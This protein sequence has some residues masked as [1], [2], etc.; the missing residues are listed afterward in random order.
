MNRSLP[1]RVAPLAERSSSVECLPITVLLIEDNPDSAELV[2]AQLS[3]DDELFRFEWRPNLTSALIRIAEPGIDVVLLDLSLPE[4]HGHLTF[5]ALDLANV[6][7]IPVI[8]L[9]ADDSKLTRDLIWSRGLKGLKL[10]GYL[11][12]H[13]TS[14]AEL[15]AAVLR[16]AREGPLRAHQES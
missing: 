3:D 1:Q 12:K 7:N 13:Q 14:G 9:T 2:K 11:L 16:A 10:V 15:K 8:I 6:S 5:R 4:M